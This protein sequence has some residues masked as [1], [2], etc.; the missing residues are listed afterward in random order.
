[1]IQDQH[2]VLP[3]WAKVWVKVITRPSVSTFDEILR[4]P[5]ATSKRAYNWMFISTFLGYIIRLL[6]ESIIN[7]DV[8]STSVLPL[9]SL[10]C[11]I[12]LA[13]LL[14]FVSV[15]GLTLS[16]RITQLVARVLGGEGDHSEYVYALAAYSVPL[17]LVTN[18]LGLVPISIVNYLTI[19][20]GIYGIVL[21]VIA[22]R[23]ICQLSWSRAI[24][25]GMFLVFIAGGATVVILMILGQ[26]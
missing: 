15:L 1:M 7:K 11:V 21:N 5:N 10:V 3:A 26:L 4:D 8:T 2:N 24:A 6:I 14:A 19:L 25:I 13:I 20:I 18:L 16:A 17:T 12:P 22:I 9:T 23:A